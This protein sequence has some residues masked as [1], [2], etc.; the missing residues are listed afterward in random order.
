MYKFKFRVYTSGWKAGYYENT[1]FAE[2]EAEAHETVA[3]WNAENEERH[4]RFAKEGIPFQPKD[5]YVE[6]QSI[7]RIP[8]KEFV[9][10]YIPV[11]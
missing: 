7:T 9:E 6:I 2:T 3:R 5:G 8:D 11:V 4:Q 1:H 10:D